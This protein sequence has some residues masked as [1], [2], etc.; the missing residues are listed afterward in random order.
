MGV[1]KFRI[2]RLG[3]SLWVY[4]ILEYMHRLGTQASDS[5]CDCMLVYIIVCG[6]YIGSGFSTT[7]AT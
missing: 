1:H 2:H 5:F 4:I 3:I 7:L 6:V